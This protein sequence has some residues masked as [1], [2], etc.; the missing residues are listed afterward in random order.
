MLIAYDQWLV[1]GKNDT[2]ANSLVTTILEA[3]RF[4][5]HYRAGQQ[6]KAEAEATATKLLLSTIGCYW[7]C[8]RISPPIIAHESWMRISHQLPKPLPV[9][10]PRCFA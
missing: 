5:S 8:S 9:W 6:A 2:C 10:R 4:A 7:G 1:K 3:A